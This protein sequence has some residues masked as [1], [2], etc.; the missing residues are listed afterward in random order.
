M[1]LIAHLESSIAGIAG[2]LKVALEALSIL[3][4]L[5]GL[6]STIRSAIVQSF[7]LQDNRFVMLRLLFG[8]WLALALEF[9]LGADIISTTIAPS[10]EALGK[11]GAITLIRTFLNFFLNK[12]LEAEAKQQAALSEASSFRSH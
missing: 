12:E 6:L 5:M 8:S 9:Q 7:R 3:C 4:I 2:L 11:L 10:F 1:E